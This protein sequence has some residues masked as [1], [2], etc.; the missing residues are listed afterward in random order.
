M[1]YNVNREFYFAMREILLAPYERR[2]SFARWL[3]AKY[4]KPA[5]P[6][7]IK[8]KKPP[9]LRLVKRLFN[10]QGGAGQRSPRHSRRSKSV[11][12]GAF[13]TPHSNSFEARLRPHG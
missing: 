4:L 2:L 7:R 12:F 1:R 11:K 6:P 9:Q 13:N 5:K 10:Y 8:K 3:E